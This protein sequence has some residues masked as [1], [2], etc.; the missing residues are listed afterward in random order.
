MKLFMSNEPESNVLQ[1][2]MDINQNINQSD[3]SALFLDGTKEIEEPVSFDIESLHPSVQQ[4]LQ[5]IIFLL[6]NI[7]I[8][9]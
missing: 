2:Y 3:L 5:N 7:I 8:N 4:V 1:K 9:L 6:I